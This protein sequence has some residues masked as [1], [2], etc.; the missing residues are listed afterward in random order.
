MLLDEIATLWQMKKVFVI[1]I[2]VRALGTT[3]TTF[4]KYTESVY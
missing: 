2:V 4:Q 3:T 1:E